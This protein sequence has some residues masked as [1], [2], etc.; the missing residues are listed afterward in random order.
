MQINSSK[1]HRGKYLS[2]SLLAVVCIWGTGY[3]LGQYAATL[4][5]DFLYI[6]L[7]IFLSMTAIFQVRQAYKKHENVFTWTVFFVFS[8][9]FLVA[10][11]IFSL[12]ELILDQKPFPSWADVAFMIGTICLVPFFISFIKSLKISIPKWSIVIAI[13]SSC[14]VSAV[15]VYAFTLAGDF[16][17]SLDNAVSLSYPILDSISLAPAVIGIILFCKNRLDFFTALI[18]FSMISLSM[19]DLLFQFTAINGT[20]YSG[21]ISD[22]FFYIQ[23]VLLTF[24]VYSIGNP[25]NPIERAIE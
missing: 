22:L 15:A 25:R 4:T 8:I 16:E 2:L 11:H 23:Y 7:T 20:N 9:S 6:P 17:P 10:Q 21:S 1:S 3:F 12:D 5:S 24:G 13:L 19:G 18:C 14:F